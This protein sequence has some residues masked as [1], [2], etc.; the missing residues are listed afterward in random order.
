MDGELTKVIEEFDCIVNVEALHLANET[1]ELSFSQPVGSRCLVVWRRASGTSARLRSGRS[2][3]CPAF[4]L[5]HPVLQW[6][7]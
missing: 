7:A 1:S 3:S 4:P 5:V 2:L 6:V